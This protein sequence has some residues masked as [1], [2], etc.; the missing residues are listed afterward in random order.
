M[1]SWRKCIVID[2]LRK[3]GVLLLFLTLSSSLYAQID[4]LTRKLEQA[5]SLEEQADAYHQLSTFFEQ[6]RPDTS[7]YLAE[8]AYSIS[9][10]ADYDRGKAQALRN[11]AVYY[12]HSKNF[13]FDSLVH[14]L[15]SSIDLY[16]RNED[17]LGMAQ[18]YYQLSFSCYLSDHYPIAK[19]YCKKAVDI[20][21]AAKER[22]MLGQSLSLLCEIQNYIGNNKLASDYCFDAL[23]IFDELNAETLKPALYNT[24][25][26]INYDIKN[27]DIARE[28]FLLSIE[29]SKKLNMEYS[30]SD[31]YLSM[32]E[33]L[34]ETE[35]FESALDYFKQSL[36]IDRGNGDDE[37]VS[38][39]FL[40]IGKTF[41]LQGEYERALPLLEG[42][43]E[44]AEDYGDIHMQ[45]KATLEIGKSYSN[46][47]NN[48]DAFTFLNRSLRHAKRIGNGKLL[49]EC[50][51]NLANYYYSIGDL[52]SALV[53]F[54]FYDLEQSRFY[55][56]ESAQ[57]MAEL[58]TLYK[59]TEKEQTIAL[60]QQK[61][62]IQE[63]QANERRI[64][65]YGL[66]L[67]VVLLSGI[68][69]VL[70]SKYQ[71]KIRANRELE[72]QKN[73]INKQKSKIERQR[74]EIIIKSKLL[75]E[76]KQDITDSIMY[77]KRI[78]LSLLPERERLKHLFPDSFVFFR[79]KDIVSGDFY[80]IH[81]VGEKVI[82]A[83][84][85][86]TG[87]GV[88]GAFMTVLANA[89]LNELVLENCVNSPNV[90]LS[91]M[92]T[93]IREAL[94]QNHPNHDAS[95]DGLDMAVCII[96]RTNMELCY[97]GAQMG[98][99]YTR[100]GKLEQLKP[101][102]YSL[103]G[104]LYVE[105]NFSNRCIQLQHGDMIYMASDGFQDQFGGPYDKKFLR[106]QFRSLLRQIHKEPTLQ[107][108]EVVEQV[109][110]RWQGQQ[111]QTDDVLVLGVRV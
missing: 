98:M 39:A 5:S 66:I 43:L 24:I 50:Y 46:L 17:S 34:R 29:L 26:S 7:L 90:I 92:D 111:V 101:N 40:N 23:E 105:K 77:A 48:D 22:R 47:N 54:K 64:V 68:G 65:N 58:S 18:T 109:F 89:I 52:E 106:T 108:R 49:K 11:M 10:R 53:N 51:L 15:K 42:A 20:Y 19:E 70:F 28:N 3:G 99:Y 76:S 41:V 75:E 30:L 61:N 33:V 95:T 44:I 91:V 57:R 4:S 31:A 1:K 72:E 59:L 110:E 86:C 12:S 9:Q 104:T 8:A 80:W 63:L 96:D 55:E 45:G 14:Y 32:G 97:S 27:Y 2:Y 102:R 87:H 38:Y 79:P 60:L 74:D 103:G 85:D 62:Q 35:E 56:Q 81:E 36:K 13:N 84:L 21:R 78:Q 16:Q 69:M 71:L 107:Q 88:P 100:N 6:D 94:H 37:G 82:V 73:A 25:G 67:G 83:V 93:K